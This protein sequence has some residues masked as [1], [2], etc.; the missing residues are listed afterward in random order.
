MKMS[1]RTRIVTLLILIVSI[2]CAGVVFTL[3]FTHHIE[4]LDHQTSSTIEALI[5]TEHLMESLIMQKGYATYYFLS[6]DPEWIEKLDNYHEEFN[7]AL[8][9]IRVI[10]SQPNS[11]SQG[12]PNFTETLDHLESL[13][14]RYSNRRDQVLELYR[15]G[16]RNE[17]SSLH[18]EVRKEFHEILDQA[19]KLQAKLEYH[20]KE[21]RILQHTHIKNL[22]LLAWL[23]MPTSLM[24][25]TLLSFVLFRE[26]LWPLKRLAYDAQMAGDV[27]G[28]DEIQALHKRLT[29]LMESVSEVSS[30]LEESR[31]HLAQSEKMALVG[32][33][34]AGV[35]HSV[36]NPLT[37]VKMRLFSLERSL[38]LTPTQ[39]E[40]FEVI[41]EEIRHIDTIMGNF[42]EFA[43]PPRLK[44][45]K[46]TLSDITDGALQLLHHRIE[47]Y[48]VSIHVHRTVRLPETFLDPDQMKEALVNVI[49]NACEAM[50]NGGRLDIFEEVGTIEPHGQV[51]LVKVRDAG[52]G[53]PSEIHEKI[54]EPFFSTKDEGS[55]LG[56]SIVKRVV[57][58]HEGW[59]HVH[60]VIGHGTTFVIGLPLKERVAWP[61]L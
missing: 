12:N 54:F 34:A 22:T 17:G 20:L 28:T 36:R 19:K 13:Y 18:W 11:I 59:V 47:S 4:K 61:R 10:I 43:R 14:I 31:E 39:R 29:S 32:K 25:G 52:P 60:S 38:R 21:G 45:Q 8:K 56:L 50:V 23:A 41:S 24:L 5:T 57:E 46:A 58:D 7:K 30:K 49:L 37:S 33:L 55:G 3:W 35:A 51:V 15:L 44:M 48:G 16:K 9:N 1:M 27:G 42:L 6:S 40:D 2:N 26:L 53:I